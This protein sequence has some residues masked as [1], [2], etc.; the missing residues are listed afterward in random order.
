[1]IEKKSM[2]PKHNSLN[3]SIKLIKL[4]PNCLRKKREKA[5]LPVFTLKEEIS[6]DILQILKR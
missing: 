2:K 3:T 5:Q 4:Q 1:M 6:L